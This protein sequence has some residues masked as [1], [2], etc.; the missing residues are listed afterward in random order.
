MWKTLNRTS[1]S[2]RLVYNLLHGRYEEEQEADELAERMQLAEDSQSDNKN[3]SFLVLG[4]ETVIKQVFSLINFYM[5]AMF[6][7]KIACKVLRTDFT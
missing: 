6:N 4:E 2:Q 7:Q 5:G 1:Y 3:I